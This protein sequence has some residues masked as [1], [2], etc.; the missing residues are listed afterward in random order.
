MIQEECKPL[1]WR[2]IF[3]CPNNPRCTAT[4]RSPSTLAP[5]QIFPSGAKLS[6]TITAPMA[7]FDDENPKKS[8]HN[9]RGVQ[10]DESIRSITNI[11]SS[12]SSTNQNKKA[13]ISAP[14]PVNPLDILSYEYYLPS[15]ENNVT[16]SPVNSI[17]QVGNYMFHFIGLIA[18]VI[19]LTHYCGLHKR[20]SNSCKNT[21]TLSKS[22][23]KPQFSSSG[24]QHD[25]CQSL[26]R[27]SST[28]RQSLSD[29]TAD[30]RASVS[31]WESISFESSSPF[32]QAQLQKGL[33]QGREF[34]KSKINGKRKCLSM[35]PVTMTM[36]HR[37]QS[38][39]PQ[40]NPR[41]EESNSAERGEVLSP[42]SATS[43]ENSVLHLSPALK[44]DTF[45]GNWT[46]VRD[47]D[48]VAAAVYVSEPRTSTIAAV[49][50]FHESPD[51][52]LYGS[53]EEQED[54]SQYCRGGYHPVM[55]GDVFDNRYRVIRKLGWG[56]FSTVWLCCDTECDQYVALKVVKSAIHYGETA[57]DEIRLLAA[58]RDADPSDPY[59]EKIVRLMNNF[60]VR[61]VNG[62]HTCLV[63]EA[64]GCSLYK[65]I[66][67]NNYQG[68]ALVQVKSI[69]KQVLQGLHYLHSKCNIIHTDI[70]PENILLVIDN[71]AAMN[72][73]IDHEVTNLRVQGVE[74]PDSY[75]SAFEKRRDRS[76]R[77]ESMAT[78]SSIRS[79]TSKLL[80]PT[81]CGS[82][83]PAEGATASIVNRYKIERKNSQCNSG[84]TA[85]EDTE[86]AIPTIHSYSNAIQTMINSGNVSVK[87]ADLGNA[88]YD[89]HHFS[90][91]IQTRQYRSI[92]VLLGATY[93]YTADI[94]SVAC[95]AFELAT[96][97]YLFDPHAGENYSRDEDHLAHIIELLG[98]V[99]FSLVSSGK[100]GSKYFKYGHLRHIK[101]LKPWSLC[102][103]LIEKYEWDPSD[104]KQFTDF[105][106]PMLSFDPLTRASA[107]QCLKHPWLNSS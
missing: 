57:A 39:V 96:G 27:E 38:R 47:D 73:Q 58:I 17:W 25:E 98:N 22:P 74:F 32:L 72:Q 50:V 15:T 7:T 14:V 80:A 3:K 19:V 60:T 104:A 42:A 87:I 65:L 91:D 48:L 11:Q 46:G 34:R 9:K 2:N 56:H 107:A 36:R 37:T 90:Q 95:L 13:K 63:F 89:H 99:P 53:D 20:D 8:S 82:D 79:S 30:F 33:G 66:V 77:A 61:G 105:L 106:L 45:R 44:Q 85:Q 52:S 51:S 68:L 93:T 69:I 35:G 31:G 75:V 86:R 24:L 71:A 28:T 12:Y 10:V 16:P 81:E 102:N 4:R 40:Y 67:K 43:V 78:T 103:V 92:E 55:I 84:K 59:R 49:D 18:V 6:P 26:S 76:S 83:E 5:P 29:E 88:C 62:K 70:K 54:A 21:K 23:K 101:K 97:D 1:S 41:R 100:H 64:L 94:W